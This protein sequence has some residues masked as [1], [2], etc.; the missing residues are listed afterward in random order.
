MSK[1]G[2]IH[3]LRN[4]SAIQRVKFVEFIRELKQKMES[5]GMPRFLMVMDNVAFHKCQEVNELITENG[6]ELLYPPPYS[7]FLNPIENVFSK[8]KNFTKRTNPKNEGE[9]FQAIDNGANLKTPEDCEGYMRNM[10]G[11]LNRGLAE[12]AITD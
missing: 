10:W 8:W 12:E 1:A 6:C 5:R 9:L 7:P 4:D 3:Y 11:Y 2:I